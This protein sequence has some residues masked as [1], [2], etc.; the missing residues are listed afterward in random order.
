MAP[1][2]KYVGD[3]QIRLTN[4]ILLSLILRGWEEPIPPTGPLSQLTVG[5]AIHEFASSVN[6]EAA[7]KAIKTAAA[8]VIAKNAKAVAGESI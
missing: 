4:P 5:L 2:S 7:R 1:N 8:M 3:P 6:D